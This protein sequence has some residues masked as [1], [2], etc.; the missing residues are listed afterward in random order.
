MGCEGPDDWAM[1]FG[2]GSYE[3]KPKSRK[4]AS[5]PRVKKRG[6]MTSKRRSKKP[7]RRLYEA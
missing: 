1:V 4:G 7:R 6:T 2:R 5:R 3:P